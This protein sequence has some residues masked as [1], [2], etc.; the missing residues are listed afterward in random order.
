MRCHFKIEVTYTNLIKIAC[1]RTYP[2]IQHSWVQ[3]SE[4]YE[5][6]PDLNF[7][8]QQNLGYSVSDMCHWQSHGF[9]TKH[10]EWIQVIN[11]RGTNPVRRVVSPGRHN[12]V[13]WHLIFLR[14]YCR[15][16][17]SLHRQM[18]ISLH[19]PS[20]NRQITLTLIWHSR[21]VDYQYGT[22]TLQAPRIW[23]R[24][25]NSETF[26]DPFL[27]NRIRPRGYS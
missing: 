20:R 11:P 25:Q 13:R 23:R 14:N 17:C 9:T 12:S 21:I 5:Y 7:T 6:L 10:I 27:N 18:C 8:F 26:M 19:T 1:V 3:L 2:V 4:R 16:F 24:L 15:Y 22:F